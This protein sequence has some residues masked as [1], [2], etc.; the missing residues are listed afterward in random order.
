MNFC[1]SLHWFSINFIS[2]HFKVWYQYQSGQLLSR[3]STL[4]IFYAIF[5]TWWPQRSRQLIHMSV[6]SPTIHPRLGVQLITTMAMQC[7]GD[8]IWASTIPHHPSVT[9]SI[10]E[11]FAYHIILYHSVLWS[12]ALS[13]KYGSCMMFSMLSVMLNGVPLHPKW[14]DKLIKEKMTPFALH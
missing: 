14:L 7:H 6:Q 12:S 13:V 4:K 3:A 11:D 9:S 2:L 5:M 8:A 1:F 10:F